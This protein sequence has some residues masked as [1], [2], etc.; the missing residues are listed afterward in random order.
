[1]HDLCCLSEAL[2]EV[3]PGEEDGREEEARWAE[4]TQKEG[5]VCCIDTQKY[6]L[7]G[8]TYPYSDY[9]SHWCTEMNAV[10]MCTCLLQHSV[11]QSA[12]ILYIPE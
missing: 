10:Y 2:R 12:L 8:C 9:Y 4:G 7:G 3:P 5:V 11:R 6:V 1:M